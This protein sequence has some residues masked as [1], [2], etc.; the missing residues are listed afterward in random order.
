MG[1]MK[2]SSR[3]TIGIAMVLMLT[4]IATLYVYWTRTPQYTLL[5]VSMRMPQ[6]II[7]QRPDTFRTSRRLG[8]A[9]AVGE[10]RIHRTAD[11]GRGA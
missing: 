8:A 4:A 7:K 11:N 1:M 10:A 5:H 3:T 2:M 6:R 9:G